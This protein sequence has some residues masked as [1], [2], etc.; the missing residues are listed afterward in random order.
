[1]KQNCQN[2]CFF[3]PLITILEIMQGDVAKKLIVLAPIMGVYRRAQLLHCD[4][5]DKPNGQIR[6]NF[7][8]MGLPEQFVPIR[9]IR[10]CPPKFAAVQKMSHKIRII[11][12]ELLP[13][14]WTHEKMASFFEKHKSQWFSIQPMYAFLFGLFVYA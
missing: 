14:E 8:D 7:I 3:P 13:K 4:E 9:D 11:N 12:F 5:Y 10:K 1:M 6:V 2:C